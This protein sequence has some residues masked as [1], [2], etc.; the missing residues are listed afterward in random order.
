MIYISIALVSYWFVD[1]TKIPRNISVW[2]K[3]K[4][5]YYREEDDGKFYPARLK[6]FDCAH[7][8][9]FW[10]ALGHSIYIGEGVNSIMYAGMTSLGTVL[11][12]LFV[13]RYL[14]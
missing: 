3:T 14:R 8:L 12:S 10:I 13:N 11:F 2:L 4:G 7:C 9:S 5:I 6:P 1:V